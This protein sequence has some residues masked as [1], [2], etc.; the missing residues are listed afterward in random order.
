MRI[1]LIGAYLSGKDLDQPEKG[2]FLVKE[3]EQVLVNCFV[4]YAC[5]GINVFSKLKNLT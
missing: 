5:P 4:D 1:D 3:C 2:L